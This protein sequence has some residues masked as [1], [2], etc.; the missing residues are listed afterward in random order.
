MTCATASRTSSRRRP[1]IRPLVTSGRDDA[2]KRSWTCWRT[3]AIPQRCLARGSLGAA[4]LVRLRP[5]RFATGRIFRTDIVGETGLMRLQEMP[6]VGVC[7]SECATLTKACQVR[8]KPCSRVHGPGGI[9]PCAPV[10]I[11]L[12]RRDRPTHLRI[13]ACNCRAS[14]GKREAP[15]LC[16][17][18]NQPCRPSRTPRR[19]QSAAACHAMPFS[20]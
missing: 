10:G 2:L 3:H 6:E 11:T 16:T 12:A 4:L 20:R 18:C 5:R 9:P 13:L 19:S 14:C 17:T 8:A 1:R 15:S 7:G